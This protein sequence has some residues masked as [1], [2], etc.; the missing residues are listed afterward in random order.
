MA[1]AP[2]R[3]QV[4]HVSEDLSRFFEEKISCQEN[5]LEKNFS[6]KTE[7]DL[8]QSGETAYL[9]LSGEQ[10]NI[11]ESEILH[12]RFKKSVQ[13]LGGWYRMYMTNNY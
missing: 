1:C 2:L 13:E 6:F 3:Q 12:N 8:D 7:P 9:R 4:A 5:A 10:D 11:G